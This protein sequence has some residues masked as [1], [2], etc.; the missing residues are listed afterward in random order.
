MSSC[1]LFLSNFNPQVDLSVMIIFFYFSIQLDE[2]LISFGISFIGSFVVML[3][4]LHFIISMSSNHAYIQ[5]DSP[6]YSQELNAANTID[7]GMV[8]ETKM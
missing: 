5:S 8:E 1:K 6:E 3:S 4:L 2:Y 7:L